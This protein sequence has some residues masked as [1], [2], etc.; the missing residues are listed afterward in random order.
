MSILIPSWGAD[1][2]G[3]PALITPFLY[4]DEGRVAC[5]DVCMLCSRMNSISLSIA[6]DRGELWPSID[7]LQ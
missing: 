3:L 7:V 5:N 4:I 2:I 6:Y 1:I